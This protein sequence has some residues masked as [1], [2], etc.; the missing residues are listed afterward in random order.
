MILCAGCFWSVELLFQRVPGVV[1]TTAG[2]AGGGGKDGDRRVTYEDV[3]EGGSGYCEAV[4]V[5]YDTDV[6]STDTLLDIFFE[7]HDPYDSECQGND[8]GTQY[9][10]AL[11]YE[12]LEQYERIRDKVQVG[13]STTF[14]DISSVYFWEAELYHQR[15]L[16]KHGVDSSKGSIIP[17]RCYGSRGPLKGKFFLVIDHRSGRLYRQS[18]IHTHHRSKNDPCIWPSDTY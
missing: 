17:F 5:E 13:M 1:K 16:E 4:R 15:Y 8:C 10:S 7:I 14:V 2:Y 3:S 6:L 9:R 11:F 18:H 12:N